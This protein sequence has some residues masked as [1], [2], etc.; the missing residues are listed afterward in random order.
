MSPPETRLTSLLYTITCGEGGRYV[1]YNALEIGNPPDHQPGRWYFRP[2]P[3]PLGMEPG[4]AFESAEEAERAARL[5]ARGHR[6][7]PDRG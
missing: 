5:D 1:I 6:G 2:Y 7:D 4:E 3:G